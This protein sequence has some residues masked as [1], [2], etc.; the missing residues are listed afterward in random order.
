[1]RHHIA[2]GVLCQEDPGDGGHGGL[3][4]CN[5]VNGGEAQAKS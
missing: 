4:G 1:M 5:N 3:Q 2:V